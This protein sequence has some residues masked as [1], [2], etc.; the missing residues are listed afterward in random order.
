MRKQ[1]L[2]VYTIIAFLSLPV[3]TFAQSPINDMLC[4]SIE[5][6]VDAICNRSTNGYLQNATR[7]SEEPVGNCLEDDAGTI[8]YHFVAPASGFVV[9]TTNYPF[10]KAQDTDIALYTAANGACNDLSRLT[11]L[12]CNRDENPGLSFSRASLI[13]PVTPGD[14][15]Y[16]QVQPGEKTSF[17]GTE[18]DFCITVE[19]VIVPIHDEPQNA[20]FIPEPDTCLVFDNILAGNQGIGE[21][22]IAPP[23]SAESISGTWKENGIQQSVWFKFAVPPSGMVEINTFDVFSIFNFKVNTTFNTQLAI[24]EVKDPTDFSTFR[25][26][27]ANDDVFSR[28][29]GLKLSCQTPGDTLY[30]MVDG[31]PASIEEGI[32][33]TGRFIL[34]IREVDN[35]ALM[36]TATT[37]NPVCIESNNGSILTRVSGGVE[38]YNYAWSTGASSPNLIRQLPS[39]TYTLSVTDQ[40]DSVLTKTIEVP[41]PESLSVSAGTDTAVC[42][43]AMTPITLA[44]VITGGTQLDMDRIY[45]IGY[46]TKRDSNI[47]VRFPFTQTNQVDTLYQVVP[48]DFRNFRMTLHRGRLIA[49][50]LGSNAWFEIDPINESIAIIDTLLP[51]GNEFWQGIACYPDG[52]QLYAIAGGVD[53]SGE[54]F[55]N[56][57]EINIDDPDVSLNSSFEG[58]APQWLAIDTL[59]NFYTADFFSGELIQLYPRS[60]NFESI[61]EINIE[62]AQREDASFDPSTNELYMISNTSKGANLWRINTNSAFAMEEGQILGTN[63]LTGFAILED[64]L[65]FKLQYTW[66]SPTG[67]PNP[68]SLTKSV[69]PDTTTHYVL[70]V[71]DACNITTRDTVT[72]KVLDGPDIVLNSYPDQGNRSGIVAAQASG[73]TPPYEYLWSN[74]ATGDSITGLEAGFY[75]VEIID[76]LGCVSRDTIEVPLEVN[77]NIARML[78]AGITSFLLFPNPT[79][80]RIM[81][82]LTLQR[83]DSLSIFL[84]DLNGKTLYRQDFSEVN[85]VEHTIPLENLP[86]GMYV[87]QVQTPRGYTAERFAL[88]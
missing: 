87:V 32:S 67:I 81:V 58:I 28:L 68:S 52:N 57:Y 33:S 16:I 60:Q 65:S 86:S 45:S 38:P 27:S 66:E 72:V 5:I 71:T 74:G 79:R 84:Y 48:E 82:E 69:M 1:K 43:D 36:L 44:P 49:V 78:E 88:E 51:F 2:F 53:A 8:W 15:F 34:D 10:G 76:A 25:L 9:I 64:T 62:P 47:V 80:Q 4:N 73:G 3:K 26:V 30:I 40:C 63:T 77:T 12:A 85:T 59:G 11:E 24:Y 6:V 54:P 23:L 41:A 17:S 75:S 21:Q 20:I 39:G 46:D 7:E 37:S 22:Q 83:T 56:L 14:T 35:K 55:G 18:L 29:A 13:A 70:S 50:S 31:S 61:G 19:S 42:A